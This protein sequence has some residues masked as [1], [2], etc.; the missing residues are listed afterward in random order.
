MFGD[1]RVL[2]AIHSYETPSVYS[3]PP[4]PLEEKYEIEREGASNPSLSRL[5]TDDK[6]QCSNFRCCDQIHDNL[7]DLI[8][9][10]EIVHVQVYPNGTVLG[11]SPSYLPDGPP[12]FPQ[13][14]SYAEEDVVASA[15][16]PSYSNLYGYHAPRIGDMLEETST[17]TPTQALTLP[18]IPWSDV[19]LDFKD[20]IDLSQFES[21]SPVSSIS[22]P[23]I[24]TPTQI[25]EQR[26]RQ[27][28]QNRRKNRLRRNAISHGR[29]RGH[30][31]EKSYKCP[32]S[33]F[34][35]SVR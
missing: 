2:T 3:T 27:T 13:P 10:F 33:L 21:P 18:Q 9:H 5:T 1:E 14:D 30:A 28:V 17:H 19:E 20:D 12:P 4:S 6:L 35:T 8:D 34:C 26:T 22:T 25:P 29:G 16:Y 31:R 15:M 32:V 24:Y 23:E 7:H 11:P